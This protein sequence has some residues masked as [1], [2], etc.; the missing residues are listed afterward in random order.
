MTYYSV[1]LTFLGTMIIIKSTPK[2]PPIRIDT[3]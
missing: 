3:L 2:S 1:T